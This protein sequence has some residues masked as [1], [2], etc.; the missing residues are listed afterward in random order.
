MRSWLF[1]DKPEDKRDPCRGD[2]RQTHLGRRRLLRTADQAENNVE[3][4]QRSH[5]RTT[6]L[7]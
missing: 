4:H 7:A 3:K 6:S 2:S 5:L 1:R